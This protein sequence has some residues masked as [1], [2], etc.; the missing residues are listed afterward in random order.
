MDTIDTINLN[1]YAL[2]EPTHAGLQQKIRDAEEPDNPLLIRQYLDL[3]LPITETGLT[4]QRQRLV[5]QCRL[6]IET[7]A[8]E[9]LPPHWRCHCLDHIY[10]PLFALAR[11][12]DC[13]Q[14]IQQ[15]RALN[16]ELRV[17][18][19]YLQPGLRA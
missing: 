4:G 8:D 18:S 1:R 17:I 12:A 6:L 2:S 11:L 10:L 7:I 19:H 5:S 15:V 16:H 3:D 9:C 13:S 14:S